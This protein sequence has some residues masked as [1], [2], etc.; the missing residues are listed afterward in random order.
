MGVVI[1]DDTSREHWSWHLNPL[2]KQSPCTVGF[3]YLEKVNYNAI[4]TLSSTIT[5]GAALAGLESVQETVRPKKND[6]M[7]MHSLEERVVVQETF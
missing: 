2:P 5:Y 1:Q 3:S 4:A 7:Y 6:T